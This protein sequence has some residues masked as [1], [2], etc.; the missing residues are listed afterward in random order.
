MQLTLYVEVEEVSLFLKEM[1]RVEL[2][3]RVMEVGEET[4]VEVVV[5][6]FGKRRE[7]GWMG[8]G[9]LTP[10]R[11]SFRFGST[12]PLRPSF[13]TPIPATSRLLFLKNLGTKGKL[14]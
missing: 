6:G 4:E 11:G 3:I 14:L 2:R 9:M 5:V 1:N 12:P 8:C 13:P 7:C 10:P